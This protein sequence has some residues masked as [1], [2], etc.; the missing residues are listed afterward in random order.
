MDACVGNERTCWNTPVTVSTDD[1][2]DGRELR[3]E[4][5]SGPRGLGEVVELNEVD[6]VDGLE[7]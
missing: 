4:S 2:V 5:S 3:C 6:P 1:G 7:S